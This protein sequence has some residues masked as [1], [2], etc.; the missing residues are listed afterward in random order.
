[1]I[2][3]RSC[4]AG[5]TALAALP[6]AAD[7][8]D[9]RYSGTTVRFLTERNAHQLALAGQL[10]TAAK[11]RGVT[12][13]VRYITTD[14]IE[15]KVMIDYVGGAT[16]WDLV[17][18]GGI[19]RMAQWMHGGVIKDLAPIIKAA[20]DQKLLA[21]DDF[22]P[23]A[24]SA[25]TLGN[26]I[27]GL[28][29]GTSE[30]ALAYRRDLFA[31]PSEM[32]AF[33]S[34]YGYPLQPPQTYKQALDAAAFFTRKSGDM[35]AGVKLTQPFYGTSLAAK[36]GTFLWHTYENFV[37]AFGVDVFDAKSGKSAL[38]SPA[39]L[40]AVQAMQ[41]FVPFMPAGFINMA[42]SESSEAFASGQVAFI[43]EY[44]DRLLLTLS[45]P[46]PV[47]MDKTEFTFLP[48][49]EGN[50]KGA[51]HGARSGPP[52]VSIYGRSANA[53]AA[54]KL[55]E[56]AVSMQGQ[57]DMAEKNIAY[58][59]SRV[60]VLASVAKQRPV[61][62]YLLKLAQSDTTTMTDVDILP[63]PSIMKAAEI[64]DAITGSLSEILTGGGAQPKLLQAQTAVDRL[65]A[66]V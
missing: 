56:D 28:T 25:V 29:I 59:P 47:G 66:G 21:W 65:V 58:L 18:T 57:Q 53:E 38:A 46:G 3:R 52:V 45:R 27:C 34:R 43:S 17:Y 6:R 19:Q 32:A 54:Y 15:K 4:L 11:A 36:R 9:N 37:T 1:M 7:A 5:F 60:S 49:A 30:Q 55:L 35:L 31:D 63:Y 33:Q 16:T 2:S 40:A 64:V 22:T 14:E 24:R 8:A 62:G 10:A 44:F 61:L 26:K 12:L 13:D 20:G 41:A 39:G 42:S 23:S 50:P 48:T 51:K